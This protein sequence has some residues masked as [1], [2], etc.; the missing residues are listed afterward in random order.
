MAFALRMPT[1][2]KTVAATLILLLLFSVVVG[3][4]KANPWIIFGSA[5]PIPGTIPPTITT[6][7]PQNNT[8]YASNNVYF[9]F[10]VSKPQPPT[11]LDAGISVVRCTLDGNIT[12]FYFCDHYS[13]A[14]PPGI[15][16][17]TYSHNLTVPDGEHILI[18]EASG[19]VLPGDMTLLWLDSN[20]TVFFTIDT[21]SPS[22]SALNLEN[23]TYNAPSIPLNFTVDESTSWI[24]YSLDE[25]ANV[26]I[27][28]NTTLTGLS[29]GSHTLAMYAN[30]TVG[31]MGNSSIVNFNI[32]EPFL[33]TLAATSAASAIAVGVGLVVYFGKAK[34]EKVE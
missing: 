19:V 15:P 6:S 21:T 30:D 8:A 12:A 24:G 5:T 18:I 2:K 27:T 17:Y 34:K 11:P 26:T 33:T 25:Q 32:A 23:E 10:N 7:S 16:E 28:G 9:S 14:Y 29:L 3:V 31:N 1:N 22:I 4:A 13:S 20:A